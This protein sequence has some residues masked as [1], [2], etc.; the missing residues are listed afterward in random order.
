MTA[1]ES[2]D[3][4]GWGSRGSAAVELSG[5]RLGDQAWEDQLTVTVRGTDG[6][7]RRPV[8]VRM[9]KP[10]H[11]TPADLARLARDFETAATL[12]GEVAVHAEA[13]GR[14]HGTV[15]VVFPDVGFVPLGELLRA[16]PLDLA[17]TLAI[18]E[19]LAANLAAV[20]R[21]G[22]VHKN[23]NLSSAWVNATTLETRLGD[24]S[25]CSRGQPG[26]Q[27]HS[28]QERLEGHPHFI[29]P[30][31]SGRMNRSVDWRTDFYSLGI[32][33]YRLLTGS[34]PFDSFDLL[35]V[36]HGHIARRPPSPHEVDA[37]V[38]EPLSLVVMKLIAKAAE[39]RY[40]SAAGI[41]ADLQDCLQQWRARRA[42][43]DIVPGARDTYEAFELPQRLYGRA[44]QTAQLLA[45]FERVAGGAAEMVLVA[46]PTG[47]GKSALVQEVQKP[48][49]AS[50][51]YVISGK[52][53]QFKA[54][55]PYASVIQAFEGLVR[56]L[57]AGSTGEVEGW[58]ARL[59]GGVGGNLGLITAVIPDVELIT[60][61][62]PP[63]PELP[64]AQSRSRFELAFGDFVRVFAGAAHP[65]VLF[66][67]DL[68]W[69]DPA[70]LDLVR[71]LLTH[72]RTSH[73]L[74]IGAYRDNE[75]LPGHRLLQL[76]ESLGVAGR[77]PRQIVLGPLDAPQVAEFVADTFRCAPGWAEPLADLVHRKTGGNPFFVAQ[78]LRFLHDEHLVEW[79]DVAGR[80]TWDLAAIDARGI[81]DSVVDLMMAKLRTLDAATRELLTVAACIGST[82]GL[83]D[84]AVV[85]AQPPGAVAE[86]LESAIHEGLVVAPGGR[87]AGLLRGR[88]GGDGGADPEF[89][90][91]HDRVQ[92]AAYALVPE[93]ERSRVRYNAGRRLLAAIPG[94]GRDEVPFDVI[95]NLNAGLELPG[96][97]DDPVELAGLNRAAGRRARAASAYPAARAYA[98][99][100]IRLLP[101]DA[102]ESQCDLALGL[103]SELFECAYVTG[104]FD[105][106]AREFET[107]VV[108][109]RTAIEKAR[110]FYTRVLLNTSEGHP[111][112]AV[113]TGIEALRLFGIGVPV[114]ARTLNV[115]A[116]VA[117]VRL[118]LRRRKPADLATLPEMTEP[119]RRAAVALL[120][121]I[122]PAAY[123]ENPNVMTLAALK[124]VN[125]TLKHGTSPESAFGYVL[126]GLVT[127]AAFGD[128]A[129]GHAFG[130]LAVEMSERFA[131][132][133]LIRSKVL[134]VHG[135]FIDFWREP[136]DAAIAILDEAFAVAERCGDVQYGSYAANQHSNFVLFRGQSVDA[137][138]DDVRRFEHYVR[139]GRDSFPID[140]LDHRRQG[141][142]ALKGATRALDDLSGEGFD[143]EAW[144][145][146]M[147]ARGNQTGLIYYLAL[148]Q[149]L[150]YLAGHYADS[151]AHSDEATAAIAGA[152]SQ[153]E[154]AKI[155]IYRGL[156]AAAL[157]RAGQPES[158][159]LEKALRGA[160]KAVAK[161]AEN[162][163]ANFGPAEAIL[164]AE[165]A[166]LGGRSNDAGRLYE[167]AIARARE[168]GFH[169][170]TGIGAERAAL[171]FA[172]L[173]ND[174]VARAYLS[175]A[176]DAFA[177]WGA[178]AKVALLQRDHPDLARPG[179]TAVTDSAAAAPPD[180]RA[181]TL[182]L[183]AVLR[184]AT[185][186]YGDTTLDRLLETLAGI[187]LETAGAERC[188]FVIFEGGEGLVQAS[189]SAGA[190]RL[191]EGK[192]VEE[193]GAASAAIVNYVARTHTDLVLD[194]ATADP[195]FASCPYVAAR[196][197]RSVLCSPLI[198]K[199]RLVGLLYLENNHATGAFTPARAQPLQII[200]ATMASAIENARM[201]RTIDEK[202][203][204][205]ESSL[206]KIQQLEQIKYQLSKFVPM[207]VQRI[208]E[209]NP[210]EPSLAMRQADV[211][212][213]F[214][215]IAGYTRMSES[216]DHEAVN[217]LL[218]R[219]FSAF[220]EDTHRNGGD[221]NA[222]AGDGLMLVFQDDDPRRHADLAVDAALAIQHTC[223]ALNTEL[224]GAYP[225]IVINIGINSGVAS[226]GS[227]RLES[228]T[229]GLWTYTANGPVT[230][231]ASRIGAFAKDGATLVSAST[232]ARVGGK[233]LLVPEGAQQFKNV[234]EP[235]AVFRVAGRSEAMTGEDRP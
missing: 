194:D 156:A 116:E 188:C 74:V 221:I 169:D 179:P 139:A 46:G 55:A 217:Y 53:D 145:E 184:S 104:D 210:D 11:A 72:P 191:L 170:F 168:Y 96:G 202:N 20:H 193:S 112:E 131:D 206:E 91:L 65:L 26:G 159:K 161:F 212:V 32:V 70:S 12:P 79:D 129:T 232:A 111:G 7:E 5:I 171:H 56:Q 132:E 101:P 205:L 9:P 24:F 95:N 219:Y 199:G 35:D 141:A 115:V 93:G 233:Y 158:R 152:F 18:A 234:T 29:S 86:G 196:R 90:F 49:V 61:Q 181:T 27:V 134:L 154:A 42:I 144:A 207:S 92:Q 121:S 44:T 198:S 148:K 195:R 10:L 4:A 176:R 138:L 67:D 187:A 165:I 113:R 163:P 13:L 224:A 8:F 54:S 167:E 68:Q 19:H 213:L 128:Y 211:S 110:L 146:A 50:R 41:R 31:Q 51:G 89:R 43:S 14:L 23:V 3:R 180:A 98:E 222:S 214:L 220:L 120:M 124:I 151:F 204:A 197:P 140:S 60:G 108:R 209:T 231:L 73:L 88:P 123:F 114:R 135:G 64:P 160:H 52:F 117:R 119:E 157:M 81:T 38:P 37:A 225:P 109:A 173:G 190:L 166:S 107:S 83:D 106:A 16:G 84:L 78:F 192:R 147:R 174:R 143:E 218:E 1:P 177:R 105:L 63:V 164:R 175:D 97:P 235:V 203:V 183:D 66:I 162:C 80:W 57:L 137:A 189:G 223:A 142:L 100:G 25:L 21:Q 226:V 36:I 150:T 45:A 186:A 69:A 130:R 178:T 30:E 58:R 17:A 216:L 185:V 125:M 71:L 47:V 34:V 33:L 200:S 228:P 85:S 126:Y 39:D 87:G 122:C 103:H 149:Q 153:L 62:Q 127:G 201:V 59:V 2:R 118:R 82:F 77:Q 215:D 182:D 102:W 155:P 75:V 22:L 208:I 133:P 172:S 6:P 48:L 94:A 230:N 99:T 227:T 229:G 136:I 15:A 28:A 76:V 40:Q